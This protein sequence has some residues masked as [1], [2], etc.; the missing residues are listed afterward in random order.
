MSIM[1]GKSCALLGL[2][3]QTPV[4]FLHPFATDCQILPVRMLFLRPISIILI[5]L[6]GNHIGYQASRNLRLY[7]TQRFFTVNNNASVILITEK[8]TSHD[9]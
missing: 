4:L 7:S 3:W 5:K 9:I 2:D 1:Y 8:Y 6:L